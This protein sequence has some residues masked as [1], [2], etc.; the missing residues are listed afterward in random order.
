MSLDHRR[1]RLIALG[2]L[3]ALG[4]PTAAQAQSAPR[5]QPPS[6]LLPSPGDAIDAATRRRNPEAA[7]LPSG[8]GV[9][10]TSQAPPS[11]ADEIRFVL[12]EIQVEGGTIYSTE[13][14]DALVGDRKGR[15]V[16]LVDVFAIAG[17]LQRLYREDGFLFTR[18]VVPA[19]A[20]DAGVVRLEAVEAVLTVVE[21]EEPEEPVGPVIDLARKIVASL[22]GLRN[23]TAER[24]ESV[25][26]RLND[27]PGIT[28][29]AAVPRVGAGER[30]AVELYVN[31]EREAIDITAFLDN[32]QSP[33]IGDGLMGVVASV[34]SWSPFG[35][36]TTFSGF[37]SAGFDDPFPADFRE[38]W[39]VQAEH[40]HFLGASGLNLRGRALYSESRPGDIV[41]DF[42]ITSDQT[43]VEVTL[44]YPARRTRALSVDLFG[45]LEVVEINSLT[46]APRLPNGAPS[47][48]PD[49]IVD[50]RL[51]VATFGLE[52]LQRDSLGYTEAR[53]EVR[54]GLDLAGATSAGDQNISR[55]DGGGEFWLIR[56]EIE[57]TL[58]VTDGWT[59]WAK[60]WG[61]ATEATLL[62]SE[63][64]TIGGAEI[65][66]A[67]FPSEYA[68]D[69]G[70][71]VSMELRWNQTV[72]WRE[73]RAPL[74]VYG[75]GDFGE[76]RNNGAGS[77][78]HAAVASAGF[79]LRAQLAGRL[80][81]NFEAARP[82]NR[83]LLYN[84][85]DAWRFLFSA[86]RAF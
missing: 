7:P 52:A 13:R 23:P 33:I 16:S 25:L 28:R 62:A 32:R 2:F 79:G 22:R 4:V 46:P 56:G 78:I 63:E 45:G 57:R 37:M 38:R 49:L 43:E 36:S 27:I 66:R 34:N 69:I 50:D 29:A 84:G 21:V 86:S 71:G 42:D 80:A 39:T 77:P 61:Q 75:F 76:V 53:I 9:R 83:P 41:R 82:I 10:F 51:T 64:F 17:E 73:F 31:M 59:L 74:E 19:Q 20:I 67:Y 68:G 60:A 26:L 70:A 6:A 81:V 55:A 72:A 15:E 11:N 85:S 12:N 1:E 44:H 54:R 8:P 30:G 24:I 65:G 18:V 48:I 14:I 5:P 3:A 58:P 47:P 35:D 40:V